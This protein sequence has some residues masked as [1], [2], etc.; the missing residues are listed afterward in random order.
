LLDGNVQEA[1]QYARGISAAQQKPS[2]YMAHSIGGIYDAATTKDQVYERVAV[3][4]TT[5][6]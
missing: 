1:I 4:E 6:Y 2:E 3:L 5:L